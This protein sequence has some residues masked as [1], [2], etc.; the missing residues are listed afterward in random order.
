LAVG[1]AVQVLTDPRDAGSLDILPAAA[2]TREEN[3][4]QALVE[5]DADRAVEMPQLPLDV[6]DAPVELGVLSEPLATEPR[7]GLK[8]CNAALGS[9]DPAVEL[10]DG[11][12]PV[13]DP[14]PPG[15][16]RTPRRRLGD[17]AP[18]MPLAPSKVR[19]MHPAFGVSALATRSIDVV[20]RTANGR[21]VPPASAAHEVVTGPAKTVEIGTCGREVGGHVGWRLTAS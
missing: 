13:S 17:S 2:G 3:G 21:A 5:F 12:Q 20:R 4:L 11:W 14:I 19:H 18:P 1:H 9:G 8:F 6:L 10:L 15:P 16:R 7:I